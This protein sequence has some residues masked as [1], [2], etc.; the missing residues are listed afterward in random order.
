MICIT[1]DKN[2][3]K[4]VFKMNLDRTKKVLRVIIRILRGIIRFM[5]NGK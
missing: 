2:Y 5:G 4:E 1:F 3:R